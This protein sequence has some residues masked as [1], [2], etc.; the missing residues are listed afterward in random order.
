M[1]AQMDECVE[2]WINE[3]GDGWRDAYLYELGRGKSITS[4]RIS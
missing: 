4:L 2:E 3:W 1:Y